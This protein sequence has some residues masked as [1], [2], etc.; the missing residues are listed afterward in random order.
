MPKVADAAAAAG[1]R[2]PP[3]PAP[4]SLTVTLVTPEWLGTAY[5]CDDPV[6]RFR[7]VELGKWATDTD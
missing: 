6:L 3:P 4:H 1:V 7:V 2:S 5:S